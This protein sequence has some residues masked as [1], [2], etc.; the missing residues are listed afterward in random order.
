M[1]SPLPLPGAAGGDRTG[2]G[3]PRLLYVS[4]MVPGLPGGGEVM[5][6]RHL[7]RLVQSGWV[8]TVSTP[9]AGQRPLPPGHGLEILPLPRR[10]FWWPPSKPR[11]PFTQRIRA[12]LWYR[13]MRADPA[14]A[15][16]RP[17]CVLTVLWGPATL[18]AVLLA[19]AWRVP[20][21]VWVHDLF[22][23]RDLPPRTQRDGERL[24]QTALGAAARV[25]AVSEELAAALAPACQ[26]GTVRPLAAVPEEGAAPAGGWLPRFRAGPVIAHAGAFHSYHV[27]YLAAVAAAAAKAGGSLLVLT[28]AANPA[29]AE[30]R[31]TGAPFRHQVSFGSSAEALRF[32]SA[33][34]SALTIMYPLDPAAYRH[35]PLGFPSR[36]IEFSHLG[37]P[38]LLAAP[39]GN[40]LVNWGRRHDWP[41]ILERADWSELDA[42][43]ARLGRESDWRALSQRMSAIARQSCDPEMIHRQFIDELPGRRPLPT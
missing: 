15:A 16:A 41:L 3:P 42:L 40:P 2:S 10:R 12:Y 9:G 33:E 4:D 7:H 22:R 11:F 32:L 24:T 1:D 13:A 14:W 34:A 19:R 23:E 28:P 26:P 37:L 35:P 27:P 18:T 31:A 21:A 29:L 36:L 39:P 38:I 25:W 17:D 8:V 6:Y 20:L 5:V 30:L 43:V